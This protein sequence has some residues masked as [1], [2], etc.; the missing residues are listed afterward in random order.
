MGDSMK[1][2]ALLPAYNEEKTI[3][4]VISVL[5]QSSKI[6]EIVVIDDG[7]ID[8]TFQKAKKCG[9]RVIKL[10][11]NQGKGAALQKGISEISADII[12]ILDADLIGLKEL[13][14]DSLLGPVIE[15]QVDMTVGTFS[16]G[17]VFTDLAQIVS[18]YLSGQRAVKRE[19]IKDISNLKDTGYG[20]EVAIN[21]YIKRNGRVKYVELANLTHI[22]KEEKRGIMHGFRD[23]VK[24]YWDI[25]KTFFKDL[26]IYDF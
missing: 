1:I 16:K 21:S 10:K 23:R 14:I 4:S 24:M 12:L 8:N 25:I 11:K 17:R 5:K 19:L 7:S 6:N 15:Q 22:M 9:A 26:L 13:H 3:A 2:S 18:P 20:A